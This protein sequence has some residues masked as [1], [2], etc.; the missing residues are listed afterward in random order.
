MNNGYPASS[1]EIM[2]QKGWNTVPLFRPTSEIQNLAAGWID[3]SNVDDDK[4]WPPGSLIVFY[5]WRRKPQLR[6][7]HTDQNSY[8]IQI[9]WCLDLMVVCH[10]LSCFTFP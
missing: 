3:K 5:G 2:N 6:I 10:Y 7:H 9:L 1:F 4:I 8:R